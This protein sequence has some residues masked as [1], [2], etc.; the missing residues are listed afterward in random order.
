MKKILITFAI[1]GLFALQG[2]S[3]VAEDAIR[4]RQQ[5]FGFG[6]RYLA[7]GGNGV[8]LADDYSAIYW[9]PAG[10][11][12]VRSTQ[13][14][15]EFSHLRFENEAAFQNNMM[16]TDET[17]TRLRNLGFAVPF[18]TTRGSFV[19][20]FG[21]NFVK[22]FDDYLYFSGYNPLSNG[23]EFELENNSTYNWYPFD[24]EVEQQE[25]VISE[26]GLHQWSLGAAMAL[27]PNFDIGATLNFWRGEEDY[28]MHFQQEDV[29]DLYNVFPAD[30]FSYSVD[31]TIISEYSGAGMKLGGMFKMNPFTRLGMS[32]EF[33]TTFNVLE[34]YSFSDELVFDDGYSD[35]I[36]DPP[37][38][39]EYE[40]RTPYRF[41][42]GIG[43]SAE[44]IN[45]TAGATYQ[46]WSQTKFQ[47]PDD[48]PFDEDYRDLL[49]ENTFIRQDYQE[50]I[51]YHLGG[52]LLIPNNNLMLRA[53]YAYFPSPL[54]DAVSDL[55]RKY[56]S[57]GIGLKVGKQSR[58]DLTYVR[59]NWSRESSDSY[60]PGGTLE[61]ITE[62]R[63]Y[64]GFNIEF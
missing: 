35:A 55:N 58:L 39:W 29:D 34:K 17:F 25:E 61:D 12:S 27:S 43:V 62:H 33:P 37:G 2:W 48:Y 7:M 18:P 38:E 5:E 30:F 13:M 41:D 46:D 40:V 31:Q 6:A 21:Y 44:N 59:G 60:T 63:I 26:G 3:Q 19:V 36:E 57:G 22:D 51:N 56:Y 1:T 10:L 52:E 14:M 50:T 45:L 64:V 54:K 49:D 24:Q 8:A 16:S 11:A 42:A 53:G 9:N 23:L 47:M 20:G 4:V 32:V 28:R 15:G